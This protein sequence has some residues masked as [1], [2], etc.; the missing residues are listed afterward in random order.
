VKSIQTAG[1]IQ[2][3][4][5]W[6]TALRY[7]TRVSF[8]QSAIIWGPGLAIG[9]LYAAWAAVETRSW[10]AFLRV[11]W[12]ALVLSATLGAAFFI[13]VFSIAVADD[14][15][16]SRRSQ[17]RSLIWNPLLVWKVFLYCGSLMFAAFAWLSY[18]KEHSLT[19]SGLFLVFAIGSLIVARK[20]L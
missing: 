19:L 18:G 15:R 16:R 13:F 9:A 8:I 12:S 14:W 7:Y 2:K 10:Q 17:E 11:M 4:P 6:P 3:G 5:Y 1:G 20:C